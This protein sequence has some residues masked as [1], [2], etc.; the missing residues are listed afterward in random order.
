MEKIE[1][2]NIKNTLLWFKKYPSP[3]EGRDGKYNS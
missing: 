2:L 3:K 1:N